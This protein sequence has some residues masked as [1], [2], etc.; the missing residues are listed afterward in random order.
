MRAVRV[1][2]QDSQ[3]SH[4]TNDGNPKNAVIGGARSAGDQIEFCNQITGRQDKMELLLKGTC[5]HSML[6]SYQL[7][8]FEFDNQAVMRA[9]EAILLATIQLHFILRPFPL[10]YFQDDNHRYRYDEREQTKLLPPFLV[11]TSRHPIPAFVLQMLA[12]LR[13]QGID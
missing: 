6:S 1:D 12:G 2:T 7:F 5:Y 9:I 4:D 3:Q 13:H 10:T 11:N 8:E